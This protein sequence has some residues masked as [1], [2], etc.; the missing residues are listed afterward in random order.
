MRPLRAFIMPRNTA[1]LVRKIE[2]RLVLI[3][4]SQSSS[5]IRISSWSR[6]IP[7]LLTRMLSWP[8]SLLMLSISASTA[9]ASVTFN[10]R[11]VPPLAPSRSAMAD[12]PDAEVAVPITVAPRF[13]SSSAIAAPM[14]RLAPVT[15]AISP[16]NN[17]L[18]STSK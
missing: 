4:A 13:A 9:L 2:L 15:K 12:A 7:A 10:S 3:T 8:N 1:L 14:P 5:F 6:V 18:M 17:P 11:P 16:L